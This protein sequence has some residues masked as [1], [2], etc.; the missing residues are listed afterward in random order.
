MVSWQEF[1]VCG[2]LS[3]PDQSPVEVEPP[4]EEGF[5]S[6]LRQGLAKSREALTGEIK[7]TAF[8]QIDSS[9]WERLEEALIRADVGAKQT[10]AIV[11]DLESKAEAGKIASAEEL[12]T[13]LVEEIRSCFSAT[14]TV[15]IS[16]RPKLILVVGVNGTGKTTTIGKLAWQLAQLG[17]SVLLAAADTYRA[18]AAEQLEIWSQRAGCDLVKGK[19]GSDPAAVVYD[20]V[21]AAKA[22]SVDVV[23]CDTAGRLHTEVNLMQELAKI[24]RVIK[25]QLP[26]STHEVLLTVDASTGQNGLQQAKLFKDAVAVSGVCLTKLDGSAKGGIAL[27]IAA[28]LE[29]PIKLIGV[30]ES[31]EDLRP[32]DAAEFA[33]ALVRD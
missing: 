18:A 19:P 33:H 21:E 9:T 15:D 13:A 27:A 2:D 4:E 10:A 17:H 5:F 11:A 3:Y 14:A 23:I 26:D 24:E 30:G 8:E 22:R 16:D 29:V 20:A 1:F 32:F 7:A 6:R 28:E 31:L 12:M 25:G